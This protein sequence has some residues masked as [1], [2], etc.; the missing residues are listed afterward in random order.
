[1]NW[2]VQL[3]FT[4]HNT[5]LLKKMFNVFKKYQV[6]FVDKDYNGNKFESTEDN[7]A[8]KESKLFPI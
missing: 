4:A 2:N 6:W 8:K 5:V 1:M 7:T 3:I